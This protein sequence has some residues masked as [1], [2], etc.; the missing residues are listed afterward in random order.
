MIPGG[1]GNP[2]LTIRPVKADDGA[3]GGGEA[4]LLFVL[5]DSCVD[6]DGDGGNT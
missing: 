6:V 4:G 2:L 1:D 3:G 5:M